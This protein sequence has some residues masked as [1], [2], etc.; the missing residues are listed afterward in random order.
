[1]NNRSTRPEKSVLA[2]VFA[3]CTLLAALVAPSL[4]IAQ[5]GPANGQAQ[6]VAVIGINSVDNILED[7]SFVGSLVGK[8]TLADQFRPM[9]AGFA[10]GLDSS[11][12]IGMIVNIGDTGPSGAL[13]LP[14]S[15]LK[16]LL[17]TLQAFFGVTSEEGSNGVVEISAQGIT[18]FAREASGW[19]FISPMPQMLESLPADPGKIIGALTQD[20]DIGVRVHVQNIPEQFRQIAIEQ[21]QQG[22]EAGLSQ[23]DGETDKQ[24]A[25]REELSQVQIEQLKR[26][27]NELDELTFGLAVDAEK[28]RSFLD[29]VYTA[30]PGTPLA[31]QM[32]LNSDPKTNFAGF[33]QPDAAMM[34]SF[35]SR[36]TKSDIAQ[37]EQTFAAIRKQ[38][39]TTIDEASD[40]ASD[41]ER[42][43]VK[44]AMDDFLDASM[45]TLQNGVMDGGAVLNL[46]PTSAVLIAGGLVSDPD[47]VESGLQKLADLDSIKDSKLPGVAWNSH[48]HAGVNF[49]TLSLP[50]PDQEEESRQLFGDSVDVAVGIGENS[51]FFAFGRDCLEGV[52][53]IIDTSAANPEKS[54]APMEMTFALKQIMDVAASLADDVDKPQIKMVAEMLANSA[55]GRDH[56]RFVIQPIAHGGRARIEA[57]EGVLRAIGMAVEQA[58]TEASEA[59]LF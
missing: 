13:C 41:E 43:I 57:E 33:F 23:Q 45:S 16:Q 30:V 39:R 32:S 12:P 7:M 35:A 3:A 52:K 19:A 36:S 6:P 22:M 9:I 53:G 34:L 10:Q 55:D 24:F 37:V 46:S 48:K 28:L 8:P 58:E 38:L 1:M 50:V 51:V 29:I 59:T 47:K 11:K 54:V 27:I 44:S 56:V 5:T 2:R 40:F 49:H 26:G 4:G 25:T 18:L 42:A 15:D 17:A 20:Y 21:L 14:V 31:E